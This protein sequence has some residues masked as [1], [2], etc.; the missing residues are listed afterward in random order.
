MILLNNISGYTHY[1]LEGEKNFEEIIQ[2]FKQ[3]CF[4][5]AS[6]IGGEIIDWHEPDIRMHYPYAH[7]RIL[8]E[9]IYVLHNG[10]YPFIAF[11]QNNEILDLQFVDHSLLSQAFQKYYRVLRVAELIE[12]L[13]IKKIGDTV[14]IKN[15]NELHEMELKYVRRFSA[16]T[17]GMIVFNYWD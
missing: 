10:V 7:I 2:E 14:F 11:S 8:G 16:K 9:E 12:P 6:D 5:V 17:V 1:D 4:Q 3:I 13:I 15:P